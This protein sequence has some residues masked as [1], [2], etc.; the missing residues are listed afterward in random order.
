MIC[1]FENSTHKLDVSDFSCRDFATNIA[2][3]IVVVNGKTI[4][5]IGPDDGIIMYSFATIELDGS[6]LIVWASRTL[7]FAKPINPQCLN[8]VFCRVMG[9]QISNNL[10]NRWAKL[11]A[12]CGVAE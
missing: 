2:A 7:F 10:A 3:R 4:V 1:Y 5:D 8:R 9:H 6:D 12:V 11:K